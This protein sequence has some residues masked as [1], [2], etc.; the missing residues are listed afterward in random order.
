MGLVFSKVGEKPLVKTCAKG[1]KALL[2]GK[3]G[4]LLVKV[5]VDGKD[6][7]VGIPVLLNIDEDDLQ[8]AQLVEASAARIE[9]EFLNET[10][11]WDMFRRV[12]KV[13]D[14]VQEC[15]ILRQ[16]FSD[17]PYLSRDGEKWM[18]RAGRDKFFFWFGRYEPI[19]YPL[20]FS[21]LDEKPS[22]R[23]S[24]GQLYFHEHRVFFAGSATTSIQVSFYDLDTFSTLHRISGGNVVFL[25]AVSGLYVTVTCYANVTHVSERAEYTHLMLRQLSGIH[26]LCHPDH[27]VENLGPWN[28]A[29]DQKPRVLVR[30]GV[31]IQKGKGFIMQRVPKTLDPKVPVFTTEGVNVI[32]LVDNSHS[33]GLM[34]EDRYCPPPFFMFMGEHATPLTLE[35]LASMHKCNCCFEMVPRE[36]MEYCSNQPVN[37][38]P[39]GA[40]KKCRP[41]VNKTPALVGK[42]IVCKTRTTYRVKESSRVLLRVEA[43]VYQHL[44]K[45]TRMCVVT[46]FTKGKIWL[47]ML[48]GRG[49]WDTVATSNNGFLFTDAVCFPVQLQPEVFKQVRQGGV[50]RKLYM[51]G[52]HFFSFDL[53]DKDAK[54]A[55]SSGGGGK[56]QD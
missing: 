18:E 37:S 3:G 36:D 33:I 34:P 38:A 2:N 52:T 32:P 13:G 53:E 40:C 28:N 56:A 7:V 29:F 51:K 44:P 15:P 43:A 14:Q 4:T 11:V 21:K 26:V 20:H 55:Q 47:K 39:H 23:R 22:K 5:S 41:M 1:M 49:Q 9:I 50:L 19:F 42:C 54:A 31:P 10:C 30:K 25:A 45:C 16:C 12:F 46:G 48:G 24:V 6:L 17:E 8:Q 35:T 27:V